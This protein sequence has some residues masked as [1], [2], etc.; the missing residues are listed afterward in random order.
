MTASGHISG[1]RIYLY[2]ASSFLILCAFMFAFLSGDLADLS[3]DSARYLLLGKALASGHGFADIEKPGM[4]V[5]TEYGPGLPV[6]LLLYIRAGAASLAAFKSVSAVF[7]VACTALLIALSS[8]KQVLPSRSAAMAAVLVFVSVPFMARFSNMVMADVPYTAF[9]LLVL[10]MAY[11]LMEG[12]GAKNHSLWFLT[13][14]VCSAAFLFRQVGI[15]L[16][17]GCLLGIF[18]HPG[19]PWKDRLKAGGTFSAGFLLP[20]AAWLA[21]SCVAVGTPDPRHVDKLFQ[22]RAS[23]PFAG[24]IGAAGIVKRSLSGIPDYFNAFA[25]IMFDMSWPIIP[26]LLKKAAA[27]LVLVPV[28]V[29][30]VLRMYKNRGYMEWYVVFYLAVICS[31]QSHYPRYLVPLMPLVCIYGVAG[32]RCLLGM[33]ARGQEEKKHRRRTRAAFLLVPVFLVFN[34]G[35]FAADIL[36]I[37]RSPETPPSGDRATEE[38]EKMQEM[39]GTIKWGYWYQYPQMLASADTANTARRYHRFLAASHWLQNLPPD[40]VVVARK[41]RLVGYLS[42]RK[43]VQYPPKAS[44]PMIVN[45]LREKNA[46]HVFAEEVSPGVRRILNRVITENPDLFRP[47]YSIGNTHILEFGK[48]GENH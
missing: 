9:S 4:P 20:V 13:G 26:P 38:R 34:L 24:R 48:A 15:A 21:R 39:A 42:G 5:H 47:V 3:G 36:L 2:I 11:T 41:P 46:T 23:D 6:V 7:L 8:R 37:S 40:S 44:V 12:R 32:F 27:A 18:L 17:A 14:L 45:A 28:V 31:W 29:G 22:A 25:N 43:T 35:V 16:W 1:K 30:F 10:F 19:T 33:D